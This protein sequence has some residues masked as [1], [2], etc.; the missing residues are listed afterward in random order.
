MHFRVRP[1]T[2]IPSLAEDYQLCQK[3]WEDNNMTT[4]KEFL[5]WYNNKDAP[6]GSHRQDVP[7]QPEPERGH[8]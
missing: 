1:G 2:L 4:M 3:V 5:T 7:V 6:V 8:L